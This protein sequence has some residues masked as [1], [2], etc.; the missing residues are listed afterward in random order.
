VSAARE[1]RVVFADY[2]NGYGNTV[3]LDHSDDFFSVYAQ[4]SVLLVK[5]DD[6]V[7]KGTPLAQ[8]GKNAGSAFL[9]FEVRKNSVATN[10]LYYLP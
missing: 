2:L 8:A 9:H 1:G 5:L 6:V 7:S 3:I 10:P 4:N